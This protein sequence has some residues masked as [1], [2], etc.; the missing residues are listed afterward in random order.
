MPIAAPPCTAR[1]SLS[2]TARPPTST[3]PWCAPAARLAGALAVAAALALLGG[4]AVPGNAPRPTAANAADA[5]IALADWPARVAALPAVPVLLL[6]EQHDAPEHQQLQREAV[7]TL[8][9][10]GRLAA[11]VMEM[12]ER[13]HSTA[14]L[15][16][17]ATA[18]EVQ[19]ALR[20]QDTAWP[21]AAYGPV[22]MAAVQAGVPV[23]GGNLP[24]SQMRA[25][26]QNAA[27]DAHLPPAALAQQHTAIRDGHCGLLPE[28]Q[29][30]PMARIQIARDAAMAQTAHEALQPGRTVVL[31]A[32]N[33]H[34][35]R[36]L[37]VPTHWPTDF[38]SKVVAAQQGQAQAAI[39]TEADWVV[40]TPALPPRDAC[41]ELRERW[42]AP[43]RPAPG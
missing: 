43:A 39:K 11:L 20:W 24:R 35:L 41:A 15:P 25:A 5:P 37:G 18:T 23:L 10:Q 13:G 36:R 30:G 38:K 26:M 3:Q 12:A 29:I 17:T 31:V 8:A 34:V 4:C 1:H 6:G 28:A 42:Q 32:G 2:H 7:Q 9:A 14:G 21:W 40:L 27:W 22:V 16:R 19:A 33:G